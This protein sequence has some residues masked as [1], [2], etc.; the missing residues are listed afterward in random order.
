[1]AFFNGGWRSELVRRSI[2]P[3]FFSTSRNAA[4]RQTALDRA[5]ADGLSMLTKKRLA[6]IKNAL[7]SERS[8]RGALYEY[9]YRRA[10]EEQLP[11]AIESN[12][13]WVIKGQG[14][15][16]YLEPIIQH[17][18]N[19]G[20]LLPQTISAYIDA[21]KTRPRNKYQRITLDNGKTIPVR[22]YLTYLQTAVEACGRTGQPF[23]E[24]LQFLPPVYH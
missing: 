1:M 9:I 16:E 7:K 24:G 5:L 13:D 14:G 18:R 12:L 8:F 3:V 20:Q 11:T 10:F 6:I 4:V 19:W 23:P 2:C 22:D 17:F 15:R 21:R